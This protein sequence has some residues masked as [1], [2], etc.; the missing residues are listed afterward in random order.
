[1]IKKING[2]IN[3]SCAKSQLKFNVKNKS[4]LNKAFGTAPKGH[5]NRVSG[6]GLWVTSHRWRVTSL[7]PRRLRRPSTSLRA[8]PKV[9]VLCDLR[10]LPAA[11]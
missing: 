7:I 6:H 4:D 8:A 10:P 1:M 3:R 11:G 9:S 5:H 2:I